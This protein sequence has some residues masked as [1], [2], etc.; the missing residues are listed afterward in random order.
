M[1]F[2][3]NGWNPTQAPTFNAAPYLEVV[4]N[5]LQ[6]TG[7]SISRLGTQIQNQ[8]GSDYLAQLMAQKDYQGMQNWL[9]SQAGQNAAR[10]VSSQVLQDAFS[11]YQNQIN[12]DT[13]ADRLALEQAK[14]A[15]EYAQYLTA[16]DAATKAGNTNAYNKAQN[17]FASGSYGDFNG[18]LGRLVSE[19][20]VNAEKQKL[21]SA[22]ATNA[23][24]RRANDA[25]DRENRFYE[26]FLAYQTLDK[27]IQ[28]DKSLSEEQRA[29]LL[30]NHHDPRN[31][32]QMYGRYASNGAMLNAALDPQ[33]AQKAEIQALNNNVGVAENEMLS[34]FKAGKIQSSKDA[35]LFLSQYPEAVRKQLQAKLSEIAPDL[36]TTGYIDTPASDQSQDITN[37]QIWNSIPT[38]KAEAPLTSGSATP[39]APVAPTEAKNTPVSPTIRNIDVDATEDGFVGTEHDVP[40]SNAIA[41]QEQDQKLALLDQ[42]TKKEAP[43]VNTPAKTPFAGTPVNPDKT[44]QEVT[45]RA[46]QEAKAVFPKG[47][48]IDPQPQYDVKSGSKVGSQAITATDPKTGQKFAYIYNVD[49][50]GNKVGQGEVRPLINGISAFSPIQNESDVVES[51][52]AALTHYAQKEQ[53]YRQVFGD[54]YDVIK[55]GSTKP[56]NSRDDAIQAVVAQYNLDPKKDNVAKLTANIRDEIQNIPEV[57]NLSPLAIFAALSSNSGANSWIRTGWKRGYG[58]FSREGF[59]KDEFIAQCKALSTPQAKTGI[60]K[61]QQNSKDLTDLTAAKDNLITSMREGSTLSQYKNRININDVYLGRGANASYQNLSDKN[62]RQTRDASSNYGSILSRLYNK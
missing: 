50:M 8:S 1:S 46:T 31:Q 32:Y 11:K 6:G 52:N 34:A 29:E 43:V 48:V 54:A 41:K 60:R 25:Q 44:R 47:Y 36:Q 17:A 33:N 10:G 16:L 18:M 49:S 3:N 58:M 26:G 61:M 21:A 59:N 56:M 12:T 23:A 38:N 15:P 55:N 20:D 40:V 51:Y 22:N 9:A 7:N 27:Q 28:M 2:L 13:H 62:A 19:K 57:K 14:A 42:A 53:Q 24:T 30:K 35:V 5:A 45:A 4:R 37:Q 39:V